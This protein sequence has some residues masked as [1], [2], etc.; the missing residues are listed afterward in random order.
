MKDAKVV[1]QLPVK[2]ESLEKVKN[3]AS[4]KS[5]SVEEMAGKLMETGFKLAHV[6]A[7]ANEAITGY[8]E[9]IDQTPTIAS[10]VR[11]S[12]RKFLESADQEADLPLCVLSKFCFG[13][14]DITNIDVSVPEMI[15]ADMEN[16]EPLDFENKHF[17]GHCIDLMFL[18][19][20]L[21]GSSLQKLTSFKNELKGVIEK[22]KKLTNFDQ[23]VMTEILGYLNNTLIPVYQHLVKREYAQAICLTNN[24]LEPDAPFRAFLVASASDN[25]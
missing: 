7:V 5:I 21:F 18:D 25:D 12:F 13:E 6:E 22:N 8:V 9:I 17:Y 19:S 10:P 24:I 14:D 15:R 23:Y 11:R 20:N 1:V 2:K 16:Y 3:L 4:Q